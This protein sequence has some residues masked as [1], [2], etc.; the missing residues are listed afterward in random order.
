MTKKILILFFLFSVLFSPYS[1]TPT[2]A[3]DDSITITTYYPSPYG[4][5]RNL[6][7]H[8]S[9]DYSPGAGC[10]GK[11]GEMF[12]YSADAKLYVCGGSTTAPTWQA[13]S[14]G[15][16]GTGPWIQSGSVLYPQQTTWNVGI[17]VNAPMNKLDVEGAVAIGATYSGA[18]P[19][20]PLNGLL[21]EGNVG[22]G[23]SSPTGKL[24]VRGDE[25]RIWDGSA[26]VTDALGQGELYVENDLEVDGSICLGTVCKNAWP[27]VGTPG[28]PPTA[29]CSGTAPARNTCTASCSAGDALTR[30]QCGGSYNLCYISGDGR[31]GNVFCGAGSGSVSFSGSGD[32]K[33]AT[34]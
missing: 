20:A 3:A 8:P 10:I 31:T 1:L 28:T 19:A 13:M 2:F 25:V 24:D 18:N 17:G 22:I 23:T 7:I 6:K 29:S 30:W 14:T 15:A 34:P 5:Y 32:C 11:Q 16:G 12:F 27:G 4:V 33:E 9:T 21:V 26:T